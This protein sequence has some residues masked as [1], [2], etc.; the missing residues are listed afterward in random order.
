[1]FL[2]TVQNVTPDGPTAS[3]RHDN[4]C[5][6][7]RPI[8]WLEECGQEIWM[9]KKGKKLRFDKSTYALYL[10]MTLLEA[11][12]PGKFSHWLHRCTTVIAPD[13]A[14]EARVENTVYSMKTWFNPC[15]YVHGMNVAYEVTPSV[16]YHFWQNKYAHL[17]CRQARVP[18]QR[19]YNIDTRSGPFYYIAYY[20]KQILGV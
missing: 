13:W 3:K 12:I 5:Q 7:L 4:R 1:M 15:H 14:Q 19:F 10:P 20:H 11:S 6:S 16:I 17:A 9:K 8:S 18:V 2:R